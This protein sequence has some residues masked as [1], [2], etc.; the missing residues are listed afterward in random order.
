MHLLERTDAI[1]RLALDTAELEMQKLFPFNFRACSS[2]CRD[3]LNSQ[4]GKG[5]M[6][7]QSVLRHAIEWNALDTACRCQ[8]HHSR[9]FGTLV[10]QRHHSHRSK[11]LVRRKGF[12][13]NISARMRYSYIVLQACLEALCSMGFPTEE[14][15][16][17][18]SPRW[19]DIP[20]YCTV[21]CATDGSGS[22]RR[23]KLQRCS[24]CRA[25]LYCSKGCQKS[26][27]KIHKPVCHDLSQCVKP[28][29]AT[30]VSQVLEPERPHLN[31]NSFCN[32]DL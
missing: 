20:R 6:L 29:T 19:P 18:A 7:R 9:K 14:R 27:W 15:A 12:V 10:C 3:D 13:P 32:S 22:G 8:R 1:E 25:I 23:G 4:Y 24:E 2:C 21:C 31:R 28:H 30:T 26:D 5:P 16:P 11:P 17:R